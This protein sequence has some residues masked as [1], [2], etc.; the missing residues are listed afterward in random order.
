MKSNNINHIVSALVIAGV[1]YTLYVQSQVD[2][3]QH[4]RIIKSL[5]IHKES[6]IKLNQ[7]IIQNQT[8][9]HKNFDTISLAQ[10]LMD[11]SVSQLHLNLKP[12]TASNTHLLEELNQLTSL[13]NKK[14]QLVAAYKQNAA[15]N[16]FTKQYLPNAFKELTKSISNA[17]HIDNNQKYL[18]KKDINDLNISINRYIAGYENDEANLISKSILLKHAFSDTLED[19]PQSLILLIHYIQKVINSNNDIHTIVNKIKNLG[20][21]DK[22]TSIQKSYEEIFNNEHKQSLK[23]KNLLFAA[24]IALLIYLVL[25]FSRLKSTSRNLGKT[26]IDLEFRKQAL[27]E[28][29]IVSVADINGNILYTND[30]FCEISQYSREEL[31]GENHRIVKSDYHNEKFYKDMWHTIAKGKIWQGDICNIAKDGTIYWVATTLIPRLNEKGKPYEYIGLRT[32]ITAQKKSEL[33]VKSLARFPLENPEPVIRV[34]KFGEVI[35]NNLAAENLL[36]FW[37]TENSNYLPDE[38]IHRAHNTLITNEIEEIEI[39]INDYNYLLT[40]TPVKEEGYIN[41]YGR[42]ITEKKRAEESLSYQANHDRLTGLVNRYAFE[43]ELKNALTSTKVNDTSSILLYI[44][45]DNFKIVNDTCG[46][47]AGDEL[48]RQLA[49]MMLC[50]FRENDTL[51]RLGGDE[52]GV[53]L[54]NCD[55]EA[56]NMI[57]KKLL[58]MVNHY[59]FMWE[60]QIFEIGASIGLVEINNNSDSIVGVLGNADIACYAAKDSGRNQ[61]NI[62]NC[63]DSDNVKRHSELQWASQIPKALAE[64]RFKL[65]VQTITPLQNDPSLKPHYEILLRMVDDDGSFI[66]PGVFIPA[67]ER[68]NL[69]P[70]ID[71]WVVANTFQFIDEFLEINNQEDLPIL[72]INLSGES[73]GSE[74][75]LAFIR[76]QFEIKQIPPENFCFEVTETAAI[77]NLNKAISFISNLKEIGCKFA[78]DDFGSGLSSFSYLKSL[79]VDYLKIDGIF[80]KDMINDPIDAAMVESIN[81]VGHIMGIKTIAEFVENAEIM[82]MLS[83]LGIDYAQGYHIDKPTPLDEK[84]PITEK[85]KLK[86]AG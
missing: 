19:S 61:I 81:Q 63:E 43:R 45:L 47:I 84:F 3:K 1:L 83:V 12:Y 22:S 78:L 21:M 79:P 55:L 6:D 67:A 77:G 29:A 39:C 59:R 14:Y 64:N 5:L 38:W 11:E 66:P 48:L 85:E 44:D 53:L 7:S 23:N 17:K 62:Y 4:L 28:H 57:A 8:E 27:D 18:L 65:M 74:E 60:N 82:D 36:Q 58:N 24:S 16:K 75:L 80:V 54:L 70:A 72:A 42:D 40:L 76:A 69:M 10:R 32:D 13:E 31:I 73:M 33:E 49:N 34:S 30:K 2:Q 20:T 46:H 51:A 37:N 26:L 68:Y 9:I 56:G 86:Q 52:F 25:I 35:F 71:Q 50:L 41:I 15:L